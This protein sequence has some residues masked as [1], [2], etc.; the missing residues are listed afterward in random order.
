MLAEPL[1]ITVGATPIS[2]PRVGVD[3]TSADYSSADGNSAIRIAQST[4]GSTRRTVASLKTHKIAADP[5]T[6][7][8]TRKTSQWNITHQGPLDG[9]TATEL[10]DQLVALAILLTASSGATAIKILAGEK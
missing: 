4:S 2:L 3:R 10:K 7:V 6:A 5:I 9:F 8:N 1:S